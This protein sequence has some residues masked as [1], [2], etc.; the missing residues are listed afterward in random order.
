MARIT[1]IPIIILLLLNGCSNSDEAKEG[2]NFTKLS[3][4]ESTDQQIS[5]EVKEKLIEKEEI[6]AVYAVNTIELLLVS[7]EVAHM[8]RFNLSSLKK[9][10]KK[11]LEKEYP[12]LEMTISTDKKIALE[13]RDLESKLQSG[14]M[15]EGKL[16]KKLKEIQKL[17]EEET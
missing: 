6:T 7:F 12:K 2:M 17:S 14:S 5:N 16:N 10:I 15:T 4:N 8:H 9:E 13:L 3:M 11:E 1:I